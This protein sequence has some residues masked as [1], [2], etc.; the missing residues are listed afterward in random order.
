MLVWG[1]MDWGREGFLHL[2][3]WQEPYVDCNMDSGSKDIAPGDIEVFI[4][5]YVRPYGTWGKSIRRV[6][7]TS[8]VESESDP[9]SDSD[10]SFHTDIKIHFGDETYDW[11]K[12]SMYSVETIIEE[13]SIYE[14]EYNVEHDSMSQMVRTCDGKTTEAHYYFAGDLTYR[15]FENALCRMRL[16]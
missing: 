4:Y 13:D 2:N 12:L 1:N 16:R 10:S 9:G 11:D 5:R 6:Q 15:I 14:M 7:P 8:D 3:V